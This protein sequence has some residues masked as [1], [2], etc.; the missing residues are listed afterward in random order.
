VKRAFRFGLHFHVLLPY[1]IVALLALIGYWIYGVVAQVP[2]EPVMS[3]I[4]MF[5]GMFFGAAL[6]TRIYVRSLEKVA[7]GLE[8]D[9][10]ARLKE[11]GLVRH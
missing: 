6:A 1:T 9:I 4:N 2:P 11:Q 7:V 3:M 10:G 8:N 5:A